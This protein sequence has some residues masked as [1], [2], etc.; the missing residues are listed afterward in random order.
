[1]QWNQEGQMPTWPIPAQ[2]K[3]ASSLSN[4]GVVL[5]G[6]KVSPPVC[7]VRAILRFYNVAFTEVHVMKKENSEY[8][9]VPVLDV[10]SKQINDS[11]VI[12]R[13][14]ATVLEQKEPSEREVEIDRTTTTGLMIALEVSVMESSTAIQQ[15]APVMTDNCCLQGLVWT[16]APCIPCL[17]LSS[18]LRQRFPDLKSLAAYGAQYAAWLGDQPFFKV[19]DVFG[20]CSF[21]SI[22]CLEV[23]HVFSLSRCVRSF[24]GESLGVIDCSIFGVLEPFATAGN[25]GFDEFMGADPRLKKWWA[26]CQAQ[27]GAGG[28]KDRK[29]GTKL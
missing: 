13:I 2:W 6:M 19:I 9:K 10:G 3:D 29:D 17:N 16:L 7:K 24:Q 18:R 14:L 5:H 23:S 26:T 21:V 8:K 20:P 1:M 12:C 27:I 22:D 15:C 11:F 25:A 28:G 4:E